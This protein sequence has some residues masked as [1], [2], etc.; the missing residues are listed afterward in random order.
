[1]TSRPTGRA[2]RTVVMLDGREVYDKDGSSA[3]RR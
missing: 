3:R 2:G 1:V